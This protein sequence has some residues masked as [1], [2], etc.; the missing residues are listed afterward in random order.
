MTLGNS[1]VHDARRRPHAPVAPPRAR[2]SAT[3]SRRRAGASRS[4]RAQRPTLQV[5]ACERARR[6]RRDGHRGAHRPRQRPQRPVAGRA[7][8]RARRRPRAHRDRRR[9]ARGH[10]RGAALH[11]RARARPD[12][13]QRRPRA[14][15]RRPHGRGRRRLPGPRDGAR[16]GARG[17]HRGDPRAADRQTL[18][19]PRHGGDPRTATASR[20]RSRD[21]A[22]VLEPVGTAPGLVVPPP[23]D[24]AGPTVVVLPGPPRELQPMWARRRR[25]GRA[26]RRARAARPSTASARCACS[27]SPSP[28]SPRRCAWPS[29]RASS[30]SALE[31]TTCLKRGEVEVVTRYE[32]DAEDGLRALRRRWSPSAT[33][34]RCSP[35]TARTVDELVAAL[36]RGEDG[37]G[38]T[39]AD[40]RVVH[41]RAAGGAPDRP[42]GLLR[43]LRGAIVAYS[44]EAKATLA[45]VPAELI[46]RHGAV[47]AEVAEALADGARAAPRSRR[48]RRRHRRRGPGR[49]ERGE[50]R[51]AGLA[52]RRRRRGGE[53]LTRSV[54]LPGGARRHPR[55]RHDGRAAPAAPRARGTLS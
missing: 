8:A 27:A 42:A 55:P 36:L 23:T 11:G 31:V 32:P 5:S 52:E 34:T 33:P 25:D 19:E 20:R 53:P 35:T 37:G 21:G 15:R 29:A 24:G 45:G 39:V 28:R 13:H 51:R 10:A 22:T 46:E 26:A 40:G 44:N 16:R 43:L 49:R 6:H 48:R 12:H 3:R 47:S 9:P 2:R 1:S 7:P 17:A 30:S 38:R 41:R 54:N 50:A 14:D 18:A 4:P